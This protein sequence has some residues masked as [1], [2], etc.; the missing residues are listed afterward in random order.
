MFSPYASAD[1]PEPES[2]ERV[3]LVLLSPSLHD[4]D[5]QALGQGGR[6]L[7]LWVL[8][9]GRAGEREDRMLD[10]ASVGLGWQE[11]P[12]LSAFADRDALET[13]YR[14]TYPDAKDGRVAIHVGQLWAFARTAQRGDL[15]VVPLKTR[16]AIA[17]G[18]FTGLYAHRTD[19]GADM[20][21]TRPVRWIKTDIP[22]S[23][24]EQDL[25]Y[26][27]G[28][29]LTFCR[30]ER[31]NAEERDRRLVTDPGK[32]PKA[33]QDGVEGPEPPI[34]I[35]QGARDQILEFISKRFK[36]HDLARLVD[37]LLKAQ[38]LTTKLSPPG[39]DG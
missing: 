32:P 6:D 8:K 26:T 20:V 25:L 34:D 28:A 22:R 10:K 17:I 9:G 19:L 14:R 37:E 11:L 33:P 24:F 2:F 39:P 35:E 21:H 23:R 36:G 29:L 31:N 5:A 15:V 30:A 7:A 27:F 3:H 12:D 1:S 18:E 13:A 16:S 4:L 38:D